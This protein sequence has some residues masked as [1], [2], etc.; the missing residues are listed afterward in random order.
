M[1]IMLIFNRRTP[2]TFL[3]RYEQG[4]AD[5]QLE[6]D[7]SPDHQSYYSGNCLCYRKL[8][9]TRL[10]KIMEYTNRPSVAWDSTSLASPSTKA[11]LPP[12]GP[13]PTTPPK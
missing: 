12:P 4:A 2:C 13:V 7:H 6:E 5:C 9:D 3:D 1:T 8:Q 11:R 10:S